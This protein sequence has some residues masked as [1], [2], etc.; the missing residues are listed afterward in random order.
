MYAAWLTA[1]LGRPP[2]DKIIAEF[3][4]LL[5]RRRTH[6]AER[7]AACPYGS[8]LK[9]IDVQEVD[10]AVRQH[11]WGHPTE[12][13]ALFRYVV[14]KQAA[15]V[16]EYILDEIRKRGLPEVEAFSR[17]WLRV[18]SHTASAQPWCEDALV[19]ATAGLQRALAARSD[20]HGHRVLPRI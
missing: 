18:A 16:A 10:E 6:D 17:S 1:V 7:V 5:H 2:K 14:K 15:R 12:L 4:R 19:R 13:A 9:A 8:F 3:E 11:R 20:M